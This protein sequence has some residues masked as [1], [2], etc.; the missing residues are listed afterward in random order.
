MKGSPVRVRASAHE[1]GAGNGAFPLPRRRL[2]VV[3]D[4]RNGNAGGA[5]EFAFPEESEL[6]LAGGRGG[7]QNRTLFRGK[8]RAGSDGTTTNGYERVDERES[9]LSRRSR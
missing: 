3:L 6:Y 8:A 9:Y 2:Q 5:T 7:V 1:E 4:A